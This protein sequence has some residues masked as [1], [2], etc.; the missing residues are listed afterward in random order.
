MTQPNFP[1]RRRNV[2]RRQS[3]IERRE[4]K[5]QLDAAINN[6]IQGLVMFDGDERLVL[7]NSRFIELYRLSPDLVKKGCSYLDL[8]NHCLNR[9][10]IVGAA[11]TF[12]QQLVEHLTKGET[13]TQLVELPGARSIQVPDGRALLE[14]ADRLRPD[15]AI[16][17]INMPLL[18]GLDAARQFH[19]KMP[20]IKL[21]FLTM[22]QDPWMAAEAFS[23]GASGFLLKNSAGPELL[24]A[25]EDVAI[26]VR[27]VT[28]AIRDDLDEV[29]YQKSKN[30]VPAPKLTPRQREVLQLLAEGRR[31]KEVASILDVTTRT[32]A[33]HKYRI[34]EMFQLDT[35]ADLMQFAIEQR[36]VPLKSDH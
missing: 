30:N 28:P 24:K 22:N 2:E 32:V 23:I 16:L 12:R 3:E 33:F 13:L 9:G 19:K 5:T 1:D 10:D 31:M 36:V 4:Q 8:I 18:N 35:N 6:M 15:I 20:K 14:A 29:L 26:G 25:I 21:I 34:M 7:W 27:Y 11:E 17:D